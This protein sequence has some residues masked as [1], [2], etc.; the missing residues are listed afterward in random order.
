MKYYALSDCK[1]CNSEKCVPD[2]L[3]CRRCGKRQISVWVT[4]PLMGIVVLIGGAMALESLYKWIK[5]F[6]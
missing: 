2:D 5:D 6:F 1:H 4:N 3:I